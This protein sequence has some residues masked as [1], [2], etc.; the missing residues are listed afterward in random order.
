VDV[1]GTCYTTLR[2]CVGRTTSDNRDCFPHCFFSC[3]KRWAS[4]L[5]ARRKLCSMVLK[6][7]FAH[8]NQRVFDPSH[9]SSLTVYYY[10]LSDYIYLQQSTFT[11]I[12]HT[13]RTNEPRLSRWSPSPNTSK[14]PARSSSKL[15]DMRF[16]AT[17]PLGQQ[18]PTR[19][20][21]GHISRLRVESLLGTR[22]R[23]FL[24]L[25]LLE[26]GA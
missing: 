11:S 24:L 26:K 23:S 20:A 21:P 17:T 4:F 15:A 8:K 10:T 18:R 9:V 1:A 13:S 22:T 16:R 19:T 7:Y 12:S 14:T 5:G 3:F 2:A 25:C 6:L